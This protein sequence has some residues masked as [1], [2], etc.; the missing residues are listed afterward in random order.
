MLAHPGPLGAADGQ[1][2]PVAGLHDNVACD[3]P[4]LAASWGTRTL[5]ALAPLDLPRR[6]AVAVD[7]R[8]SAVVIGVGALLGLLAAVTPATWAARATLS[9]LLANSAVRGGGGRGRLRRAMVV[10]QVTL[11]LILL[12]TGGLVVRSFDRLLRADPGFAPEGLLTLRVPM[13]FDL[14]H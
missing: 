6:E 2:R 3:V 1:R 5:I 11:S 7:W 13:T 9:S 4:A 12:S 10:A 8:I 14:L